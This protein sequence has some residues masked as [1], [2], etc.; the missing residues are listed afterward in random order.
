MAGEVL[1]L[2]GRGVGVYVQQW[3]SAFSER[4]VLLVAVQVSRKEAWPRGGSVLRSI[5]YY[6][7]SSE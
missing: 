2:G 6:T 7:Q 1:A 5:F 3:R 4:G